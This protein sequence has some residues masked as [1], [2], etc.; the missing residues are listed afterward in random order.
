VQKPLPIYFVIPFRFSLYIDVR[1][2]VHHGR[3]SQGVRM[4]RYAVEISLLSFTIIAGLEE[5]SAMHATIDDLYEVGLDTGKLEEEAIAL[6]WDLDY[7]FTLLAWGESYGD[8]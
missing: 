2:A 8:A 4:N 1:A 3:L 6:G 7:S 5:F